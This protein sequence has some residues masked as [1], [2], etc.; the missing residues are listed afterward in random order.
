MINFLCLKNL[1]IVLG[2]KVCGNFAF[3]Y[4]CQRDAHCGSQSAKKNKQNVS[5]LCLTNAVPPFSGNGGRRSIKGSASKLYVLLRIEMR[6][7]QFK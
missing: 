6:E 7:I 2:L 5:E 3:H 1:K 4:K